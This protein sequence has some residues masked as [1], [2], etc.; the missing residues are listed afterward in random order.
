[1]E[2]TFGSAQIYTSERMKNSP[3]LAKM[4]HKVFGYTNVGNYARFTVFKELVKSISLKEDAKILDLGTGYGEYSFSLAEALPHSEVHSLDIDRDRV[5]SVDTAIEK[6]G[7]QNIHTHCTFTEQLEEKD[8]D[9]VFSVDVFEHIAPE[10]MPFKA[11]YKRL[12]PGG[13]FMVKMPYVTQRTI[14]PENWFEDHHEWLE[15]EHIGQVYDLHNLKRRF[16]EEGFRVIHSSYSDGWLSRLGWEVAYLGKKV[17]IIGQL[18]T[19]P[20]AKLCIKLDR[21][22]HLNQWGNAIQVIGVKEESCRP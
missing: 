19:L 2:L 22:M 1:M 20:F 17:G 21:A 8:F 12:R 13:K 6:S 9:F 11:V 18:L 10:D 4:F 15:E 16:V 14:L 3:V 7:I 5:K